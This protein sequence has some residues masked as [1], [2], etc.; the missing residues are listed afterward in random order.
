MIQIDPKHND[1]ERLQYKITFLEFMEEGKPLKCRVKPGS[2]STAGRMAS[3]YASIVYIHPSEVCHLIKKVNSL[4]ISV[5]IH[6]TLSFNRSVPLEG[7]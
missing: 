5:G 1:G 3:Q 4:L 2:R 6:H 7:D